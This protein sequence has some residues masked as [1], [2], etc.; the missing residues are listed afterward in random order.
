MRIKLPFNLNLK[1]SINFCNSID[2]KEIDDEIIY[3]YSNMNGNLEPFGMLIV[4]SKM[5]ELMNDYPDI[6]YSDYNFKDKLY[7]ANM[8]FFESVN[9]QFG[10]KC[11]NANGN[12]NFISI[13]VEN[14][15]DSFIKAFELGYGYEIE[16]YIETQ[17]SNRIVTVLA[18]GNNELRE[19]LN[20]CIVEIIRNIYDHS[21]SENLW[22]AGQYWPTKDLVEVAILDEGKGIYKSISENKRLNVDTVEDALQLALL[23]GISKCSKAIEGKA[24]GYDNA[25][26]GLYMIKEICNELGEFT[27]VSD[28][29]CMTINSGRISFSDTNFK[30]T[31]IRIRIKPSRIAGKNIKELITRLSREGTEKVL[32]YSDIPIISMDKVKEMEGIYEK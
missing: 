11:V 27:I 4:G 23:P 18:R 28:T 13:N 3:D 21:K 7:A 30:G 16:R 22:Y 24:E 20:Y 31:A 5:R 10:K 29:K 2:Y 19:C 8:G 9:Q 32:R 15:R 1:E 12:G 14:I 25:G 6:C 17:L 26:F